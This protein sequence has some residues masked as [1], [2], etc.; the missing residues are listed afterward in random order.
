M[1]F[2]YHEPRELGPALDLLAR[3]GQD[4]HLI[5]GGTATVLLLR[6]GLLR[7]GH[8]IGLRRIESLGGCLA[9]DSTEAGACLQISLPLARPGSQDG[10]SSG[11]T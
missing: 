5:A 4:A 3:H 2:E 8:V 1:T 9:I 11:A 6:Q 7:P 10:D